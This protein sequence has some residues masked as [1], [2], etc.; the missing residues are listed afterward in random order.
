MCIEPRPVSSCPP[1]YPFLSALSLFFH[2]YRPLAYTRVGCCCRQHQRLLSL[3]V[4]SRTCLNAS[5]IAQPGECLLFSRVRSRGHPLI[6]ANARQIAELVGESRTETVDPNGGGSVAGMTHIRGASRGAPGGGNGAVVGVAAY[7]GGGSRVVGRG[8]RVSGHVA[9]VGVAP[10]H[11]RWGIPRRRFTPRN[12]H[13]AASATLQ[14]RERK[15]S[16]CD[17]TGPPRGSND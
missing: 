12:L 17:D 13:P 9:V 16:G 7:R 1:S 11:S 5:R 3:G 8:G 10:L 6:H 2:L 15:C 14:R 4:R